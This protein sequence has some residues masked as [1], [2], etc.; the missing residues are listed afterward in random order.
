MFLDRKDYIKGFKAIYMKNYIG[1]LLF[2]SAVD[3]VDRQLIN[4]R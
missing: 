2:I 4:Q 3:N 1:R